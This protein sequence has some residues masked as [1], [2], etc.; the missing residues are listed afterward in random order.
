ML[1]FRTDLNDIH[2]FFDKFTEE[3][4]IGI[5]HEQ[6]PHYYN[7]LHRYRKANPAT[8]AGSVGYQVILTYAETFQ[9][10]APIV[11]GFQCWSSSVPPGKD[12]A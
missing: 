6:S 7:T 3:Q 4:V 8:K 11:P 12:E 2:H 9:I 5:A 10:P 1:N